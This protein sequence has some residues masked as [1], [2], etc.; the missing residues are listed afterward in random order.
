MALLQHAIFIK[1]ATAMREL[2]G[3]SVAEVAIG[4][5]SNSGKS[6]AINA[7]ANR[8]RLA[9][10]SKTPGRT[11]EINYFRIADGKYLV[12][13]PGYGYAKVPG[14]IQ[15]R[16][17]AFL[18]EFLQERPPLSGLVLVMDSRHPLT[19]NDA[20]ML[21]WF[22][23][24]GKPVHILLTKADKLTRQ[25]AAR[26]LGEVRGAVEPHYPHFSAQLFSSVSRSGIEEAESVIARWLDIT[27]K[28]GNKNPRLKGSKTGGK[29]P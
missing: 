15:R 13:L 14:D 12:D 11:Q 20:N 23:Q 8:R 24:T 16:W 7:L 27:P 18:N 21:N 28:K 5:R 3:D 19:E 17:H 22:A 2:P 10:V 4:G 26:V 9:F 29:T 25:Q 1:S 6:S